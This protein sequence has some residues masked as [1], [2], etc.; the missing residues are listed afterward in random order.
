VK[1]RWGASTLVSVMELEEMRALGVEKLGEAARNASLRWVQI[2]VTDGAVPDARFQA[3]W[4]AVVMILNEELF[5]DR[6]IVIHCRGGLGRT[7]VVACLLLIERGYE[8]SDALRLVRSTR[9][10]TVET[11]DQEAFVL[12]YQRRSTK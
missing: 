12:A 8:P 1:R 2:P 9:P 5:A 11:C 6:S 10:G 7:G 4:P 3:L